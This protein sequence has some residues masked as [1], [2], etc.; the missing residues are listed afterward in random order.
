MA[1]R[2]LDTNVSVH[3]RIVPLIEALYVHDGGIAAA[4]L[5]LSLVR[6]NFQ[7]PCRAASHHDQLLRLAG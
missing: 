2:T 1:E 3:R 7:A 6:D 4:G 5:N